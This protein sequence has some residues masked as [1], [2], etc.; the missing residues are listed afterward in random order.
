MSRVYEY[1]L[2]KY[3]EL[4]PLKVKRM[5]MSSIFDPSKFEPI[6]SEVNPPIDSFIQK[7]TI[8]IDTA[9]KQ[10][11]EI[12]KYLIDLSKSYPEI[13]YTLK[14]N[15]IAT[16]PKGNLQA[17]KAKAKSGKT[18][19]N[20]CL[21]TALLRG[22]FLTIESLIDNPTI[23]YFA[24]EEQISSA[25]NLIKKVHR[26]C[27][28][29]MEHNNERFLAYSIREAETTEK[30]AILEKRIMRVKPDIVF[31]DGIRD[32]LIDFNNIQQSH[33]IITRLLKLSGKYNCAIVCVLHT[34]KSNFDTNMRGHLGTEL[35]N[36]CS[37]VLE[38]EKKDN[39]F[40]VRHT[41]SR[42][43]ATGAWAFCFD[44]NGFLKEVE[45]QN[46]TQNKVEQRIVEIKNWF[47]E[48]L[49]ENKILSNSDLK[50]K[51]MALSGN[52]ESAANKQIAEMTKK[53]FLK[54]NGNGKYELVGV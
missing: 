26:H 6:V 52:K 43:I 38:V 29:D 9:N 1:C 50:R 7:K 49:T 54:K 47:S 13:E 39:N 4:D 17:I 45:I 15:G 19:V 30:V 27:S 18:H 28:W 32:L 10:S 33:E 25:V 53:G 37:D 8:K 41:D 24:T 48:I 3:D 42:N 12:D 35:L 22:E 40:T 51:Y 20:I 16:F 11:D 21:M 5:Q 14:I 34:N 44:E 46:K 2:D 23:C 31:I 36:K